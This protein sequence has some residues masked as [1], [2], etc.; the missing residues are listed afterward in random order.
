[1]K[2]AMGGI[3]TLQA[4]VVALLIIMCLMAFAVNY[5]KAFRVKNEIRSIIEKNEGLTDD[6]QKQIRQ[7][8][9]NLQY[10][11]SD[12]YNNLC[13]KLNDGKTDDGTGKG[14][15]KLY[16]DPEDS[17]IHF[18][19]KC[20]YADS[21]GDTNNEPG[22]RGAY[23]SIVTY[24]N[25]DVPIVNNIIPFTSGLF[26]VSGETAVIYSGHHNNGYCESK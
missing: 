10:F 11:Q 24:V 13:V 5:S 19:I 3:F 14:M 7:V 15:W 25:I 21:M 9:A 12:T 18:C 17:R 6:A 16:T 2:D 4:I 26:K 22:Y 23:Y 20:E 8:V 1:M